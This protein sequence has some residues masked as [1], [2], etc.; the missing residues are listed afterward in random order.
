MSENMPYARRNIGYVLRI[1]VV[2]IRQLLLGIWPVQ[3]LVKERIKMAA[4]I[5][6]YYHLDLFGGVMRCQQS[7]KGLLPLAD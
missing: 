4:F 6:C 5:L 2:D 1:S 3:M 7:Q